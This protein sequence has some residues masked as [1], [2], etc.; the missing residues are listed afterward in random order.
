[1]AR[2][3]R[4]ALVAAVV[5]IMLLVPV[6]WEPA[7]HAMLDGRAVATD[8]YSRIAALKRM[9][10]PR[11]ISPEAAN[12]GQRLRDK[13][14]KPGAYV[15][16][17]VFKEER[18]LEVWVRR[19]ESYVHFASYPICRYSGRLGPKQR[20]GDRQAPEGF[21]TVDETQL[22]SSPRHPKAFNI[23]FPNPLDRVHNRTG[24]HLMIHGGC[25][26]SGCFAMTD[27]YMEELW[28]LGV[29]ALDNGQPR[30]AVHVF[31]FRM[32][33]ANMR[34]YAREAWAPFWR[35]LKPA[36]DLF[37]ETRVPPRVRVCAGRYLVSAGRDG[38]E[39]VEP[40]CPELR[41]ASGM[42]ERRAE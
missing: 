15:Y 13:G 25:T 36:Y 11:R 9:V 23:G 34:R 6:A 38:A 37:T 27:A 40:G 33:E 26:S 10:R 8:N 28:R 22:S 12:L 21:Y 3:A 30:F 39:A 4:Q 17:R 29:A 7:R 5:G 41:T 35:D 1:M 14:L 24:S 32:H 2:L 42:Q 31:P 20:S 19:D 16:L 18:E